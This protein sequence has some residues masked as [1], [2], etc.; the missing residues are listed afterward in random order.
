MVPKNRTTSS[1]LATTT[2]TTTP[3]TNAQLKALIDQGISD[4]LAAHDVDRSMNGDDNHN[5]ETG[6]KR[7][8]PLARECTYPDFMKC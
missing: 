4:A 3:G 6:S 7:Q 8:A 2:T 5:S 1:S